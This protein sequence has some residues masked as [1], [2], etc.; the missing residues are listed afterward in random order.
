MNDH[1]A[2]IIEDDPDLA[3]I[4]NAA[5]TEAEFK[6]AVIRNGK[7]AIEQLQQITPAIVLLDLHLPFV[8]GEDILHQIRNDARLAETRVILATANAFIAE[9]LKEEAD[10]VLLKPVSFSQLR[11]LA[12]RLRPPDVLG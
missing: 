4:F 7:D 6:T 9:N 5:L 3:H 12:A 10:L 8:S 1:L 2:L 11:Q